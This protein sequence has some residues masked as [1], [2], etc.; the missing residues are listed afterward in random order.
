MCF[1]LQVT[2]VASLHCNARLTPSLHVNVVFG[3]WSFLPLLNTITGYESS[4]A[5]MTH[6][7]TFNQEKLVQHWVNQSGWCRK[8]N[9]VLLGSLQ[10]KKEVLTHRL[11]LLLLLDQEL[12]HQVDICQVQILL[13]RAQHVLENLPPRPVLWVTVSDQSLFMF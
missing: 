6:H 11:Q 3:N 1:L 7:F 5:H 8:S 4:L 13:I 12:Q 10:R 9:K 2:E